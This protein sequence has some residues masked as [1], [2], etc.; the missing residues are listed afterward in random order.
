MLIAFL[1]SP[2]KKKMESYPML[3]ARTPFGTS[4]SSVSSGTAT[5]LY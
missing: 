5:C 3:S 2:G 4:N 1:W